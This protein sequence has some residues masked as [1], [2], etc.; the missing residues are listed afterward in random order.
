[1]RQ[2][3]QDK[4]SLGPTVHS[5]NLPVFVAG[6]VE[7]CPSSH[8]IGARI[9]Q[10]QFGGRIPICIAHNRIPG[11]EAGSSVRVLLPELYKRASLDNAHPEQGSHNENLGS[12]GFPVDVDR[13]VH[14]NSET[15]DGLMLRGSGSKH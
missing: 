13:F 15:T 9:H 6:N 1:M 12:N 7:Y 11:F 2:N 10:F 5:R 3:I 8:K 14:S 4:D